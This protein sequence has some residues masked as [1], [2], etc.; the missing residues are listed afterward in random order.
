MTAQPLP[1]LG[2]DSCL[3]AVSLSPIPDSRTRLLAVEGPTGF[4]LDV[5]VG[6][7]TAMVVQHVAQLTQG[8]ILPTPQ[9][10]GSVPLVRP[11]PKDADA[12]EALRVIQDSLAEGL[13]DIDALT[14]ACERTL[15]ALARH[16][17]WMDARAKGGVHLYLA[18]KKNIMMNLGG[19]Y[20]Q[21]APRVGAFALDR[22]FAGKICI[23]KGQIRPVRWAST[24]VPPG[25]IATSHHAR[26]PLLADALR[27]WQALGHD[28]AEWL[29][30]M[31]ELAEASRR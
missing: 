25:A 23:A 9:K 31:N 12:E 6:P 14:D 24:V 15:K 27:A 8:G 29:S 4:R 2:P 18:A 20:I 30:K 5:S 16:A 26:L 19:S 22:L 17:S 10:V 1:F 7:R 28:A 3:R 11:V 13:A 21:N